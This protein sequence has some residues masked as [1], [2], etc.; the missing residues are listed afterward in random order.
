MQTP[1]EIEFQGMTG[2]PEIQDTIEKHVAELKHRWGRITACRVV[3]KG[4]AGIT[5]KADFTRFIS[6]SRFQT[7]AR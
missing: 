5:A 2:T 6:A 1:P 4:R 3:L 7:D